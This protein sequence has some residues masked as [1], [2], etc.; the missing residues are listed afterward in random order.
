MMPSTMDDAISSKPASPS[1]SSAAARK[2]VAGFDEDFAGLGVDHVERGV[3]PDQLVRD[4]AICLMPSSCHL[5][6]ARWVIFV[7]AS[8]STSPVLGFLSSRIGL[9][10]AHPA[11]FQ[12]C[13]PGAV[14]LTLECDLAVE[15]SRGSVPDRGR[16]NKAASSPAAC[17]GGRCGHG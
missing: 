16:A 2:F 14:P 4:I 1:C 6:S 9:G 11:L 15:N 12:R 7:P 5:R 10:V 8:A 13:G 17:G 3:A